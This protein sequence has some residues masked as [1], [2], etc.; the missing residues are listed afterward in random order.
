MKGRGIRTKADGDT[1]VP[2]V[3]SAAPGTVELGPQKDGG[4]R[5][6]RNRFLLRPWRTTFAL[7]ALAF[8]GLELFLRLLPFPLLDFAFEARQVYRYHDRWY[9]DFQ[10]GSRARLAL[11]DGNGGNILDFEIVV[12]ERGLRRV[13]GDGA[14]PSDATVVHT[15]GDSFTMGWGVDGDATYPARLGPLLGSSFQVVN[16]GVNGFGAIGAT[17]KSAALFDS[18]PPDLVIYVATEN[19]YEDDEKALRHARRSGWHRGLLRLADG[20]R[21]TFLV[22]SLPFAGRWALQ[23]ARLDAADVTDASMPEAPIRVLDEEPLAPHRPDWGAASKEA[24]RRYVEHDLPASAS[25]LV[26][27]HGVGPMVQDLAAFSQTLGLPLLR[28]EF[29]P[30]LIIPR[31]GHLTE[32]GNRRL[33]EVIAQRVLADRTQSAVPKP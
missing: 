33:A 3:G 14:A 7:L 8:L 19:D 20:F 13:E 28:L 25:M 9:T 16:L 27:T 15:I 24:L 29:D 18:M 23:L 11:P 1:G 2:A 21:R 12:D 31:D 6:S 30:R 5:A 32:Q 10:P 22:G 17:E 4:R 26:V